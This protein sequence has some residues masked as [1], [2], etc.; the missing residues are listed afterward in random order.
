MDIELLYTNFRNQ[1]DWI[2]SGTPGETQTSVSQYLNMNDDYINH[3]R[4]NHNELSV[5]RLLKIC[6]YLQTEPRL[7]FECA[8][9]NRERLIADINYDLKKLTYK[10][11]EALR[12]Y[13]RVRTS[14]IE[15]TEE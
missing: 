7:F 14:K 6:D 5:R 1:L 4:N 12:D 11:L 13:I 9:D 10:E 3:V 8:T 2:I 15:T